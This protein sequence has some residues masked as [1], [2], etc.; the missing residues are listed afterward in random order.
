MPV[1]A[2]LER[3]ME[4]IYRYPL[5]EAAADALNRQIRAHA[6]DDLIVNLAMTLRKEGRLSVIADDGDEAP[7]AQ[8]ICSL[9]LVG[10]K[11]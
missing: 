10:E 1:K 8:I 3:T 11:A 4:D 2:W 6:A 5:R 9:G 7:R